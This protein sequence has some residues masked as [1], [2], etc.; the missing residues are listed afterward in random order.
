MVYNKILSNNM[1]NQ[2]SKL[3]KFLT[4]ELAEKTYQTN[5]GLDMVFKIL[6]KQFK[7]TRIQIQD[8]I[9]IYQ[10]ISKHIY[11]SIDS[12]KKLYYRGQNINSSLRHIIEPEQF[13]LEE[14]EKYCDTAIALKNIISS[15]SPLKTEWNKRKKIQ[16]KLKSLC[17]DKTILNI[18]LQSSSRT[19]KSFEAAANLIGA[20]VLNEKDPQLNSVMSRGESFADSIRTFCY[21]AD[22]LI[23]RTPWDYSAEESI[24]AQHS[25]NRDIPIINAGSGSRAHPTQALLDLMT[26]KERFSLDRFDELQGATIAI[27]GTRYKRSAISFAKLL[28][29]V[30][31]DIKF[32][33]ITPKEK[34]LPNE[35]IEA[36]FDFEVIRDINK[37]LSGA[38]IIYLARL[39]DDVSPKLR[40]KYIISKELLEKHNKALVLHPLPRKEEIDIECDRLHQVAIWRQVENGVFIRA[41]L[42]ASILGVYDQLYEL[43]LE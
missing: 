5:N 43:I 40:K 15:Q 39:E 12:R 7:L 41:V 32:R 21:Y 33:I 42:L 28:K 34:N 16:K 36:K 25:I 23:I 3:Y 27:I 13:S 20:R 17:N 8:L 35:F 26:I 1:Q 38:S 9:N 22:A 2:I 19:H 29:T 37:G 30:A 14:I 6:D 11:Q 31:R 24:F 4:P 10:K 18:F